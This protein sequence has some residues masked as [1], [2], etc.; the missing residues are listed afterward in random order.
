MLGSA[1]LY[2]HLK[3]ISDLLND[4]CLVTSEQQS[5][6]GVLRYGTASARPYLY[7]GNQGSNIYVKVRET[8]ITEDESKREDEP[9]PENDYGSTEGGWSGSEIVQDIRSETQQGLDWITVRAPR[10]KQKRAK[11]WSQN[12]KLEERST[13]PEQ[14]RKEA[15]KKKGEM[16]WW[17]RSR[18][19][20]EAKRTGG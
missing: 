9:D 13:Q 4:R 18:A 20:K 12:E 11:G 1:A 8:K 10:T 2:S 14:M 16:Y 17:E 19:L 6:K 3:S 7:K 15:S 5:V